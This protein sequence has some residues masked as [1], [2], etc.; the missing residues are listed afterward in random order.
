MIPPLQL[1]GPANPIPE[2]TLIE[3]LDLVKSEEKCPSITS[4]KSD[5][6]PPK[7]R[8]SF[9]SEPEEEEEE[10]EETGDEKGQTMLETMKALF[11]D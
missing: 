10:E 2:L 11:L 6:Q 3:P 9:E 7:S 4:I 8:D 1:P 5:A